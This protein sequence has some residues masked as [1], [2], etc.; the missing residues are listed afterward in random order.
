MG[1]WQNDADAGLG[2][3]GADSGVILLAAQKR[4]QVCWQVF[5]IQQRSRCR[6]HISFCA[7]AA[8]DRYH[9]TAG[10]E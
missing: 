1:R 7:D 8:L 9:A 2:T 3:E 6:T 5:G 4:R 10:A